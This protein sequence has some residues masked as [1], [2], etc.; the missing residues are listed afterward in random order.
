MVEGEV[1]LMPGIILFNAA[2]LLIPVINYK[3]HWMGY[4]SCGS[5]S[6]LENVF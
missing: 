4:D 2:K 5:K 6:I 3:M 1:K